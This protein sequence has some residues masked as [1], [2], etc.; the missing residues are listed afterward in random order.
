[1]PESENFRPVTGAAYKRIVRRHRAVV[2]HPKNLSPQTTRVLRG[3]GESGTSAQ[4]KSCGRLEIAAGRHIKHSV[5]PEDNT[6]IESRV[7]FPGIGNQNVSHGG[8]EC[9]RFHGLPLWRSLGMVGVARRQHNRTGVGH[10]VRL[11]RERCRAVRAHRIPRLGCRLRRSRRHSALPRSWAAT[12]TNGLTRF[13][14]NRR[15]LRHGGRRRRPRE[16]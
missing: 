6:R 12:S 11:D 3:A 5:A 13:R 16:T 1:M 15:G 10:E 7:A 14:Q 4:S 2:A 9:H 8:E